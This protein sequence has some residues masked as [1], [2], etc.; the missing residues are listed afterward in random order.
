MTTDFSIAEL[1]R[2]GH[3]QVLATGLQDARRRTL[4]L[5]DAY[6][7][8]LG[9]TL[10]IAYSPQLNPP[11]WELGHIAWF[12][13]Y[14]IA[15]NRQRRLGLACEP[16]HA[17]PVG[18]LANADAWYNSS[19]VP[20]RQR[21]QLALPD[22]AATR[23]YLADSL[24]ETLHLLAQEPATLDSLYFYQLVLFHEDMHAEAGTYMAQALGIPL[25][26]QSRPW[27]RPLPPAQDLLIPGCCWRLGHGGPGFAFDNELAAHPLD[28]APYAIDRVVVSWR[29]F[30]PGV[31]SGAVSLPRYVR[32]QDGIWQAQR[33]GTWQP[34]DLDT[35]AL[36]LTWDQTQDWCAW[37]GRR[38]PSEAEWECAALT[39]PE[40]DWGDVWEWTA[41][42]F[43][44]FT[45]FVAHPYRD[46]S[47]FGFEE[48]RYVLKGASRATDP[49][50]AHPR[51]RNFFTVERNDIHSGFRSCAR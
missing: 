8:A 47:R 31:A 6:V 20:H 23:A 4:S 14:W 1:T 17:R 39:A 5:L 19:E 13:D 25:P 49:R 12:Q 15:R 51:Y 22:L 2:Q 50:M 24:T 38:L 18:R 27:A 32:Q 46:Y 37:A 11:L 41:S 33:F 40:F 48:Q 29:R 43:Q 28:L 21:W 10:P 42:R 35:A 34:L 7:A 16:N 9:E 36:H 44:P 45:G 3:P 26:P 30:L